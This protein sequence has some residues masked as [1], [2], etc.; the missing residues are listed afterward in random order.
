MRVGALLRRHPLDALVVLLAVVAE[1]KV[2]IVPGAGPKVV[3]IIASL[4]WTLPLL[5]RHRFPFAAPV[6][7][8]AVQ[9]AASA[10]DPDLGVETTGL[11]A[12]LLAFWVVGAE[13]ERGQAIVGAAIGF[14]SIAVVA[15]LDARVSLENAVWGIIM[16]S[17]VCLIAYA[18]QRRAKRAGELEERA[19]RLEREREE[20]A[21]AAVV[22]ERTRIARDLHDLIAHSVSLM[23]VQAGAAR[24]LLSEDPVRA[25]EPLLAVEETGRQALAEMRRLFGIVRGNPSGTALA[26]EPSLAHLGALLEEARKAG[27]PVELTVE[28]EPNSVPPGIDVAAYR[29]VQEALTN[30]RKHA[31]PTRAHVSVCYRPGALDLEITNDGAASTTGESSG[32]GLL[33]MHERVALYGGELEAGPRA[34]GCYAVRARL[35]VEAGAR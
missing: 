8:F 25:R 27:L 21:R 14:A 10:A 32:H 5:L 11:V 4:L 7:T 24:L 22:A 35:P 16:G 6:F 15:E 19:R 33:G 12:L 31:G 13:N 30:A 23:T 17:V 2:W 20:R 1:I 34:D 26:L 29:I 18:L 3:F 28:G 9:A